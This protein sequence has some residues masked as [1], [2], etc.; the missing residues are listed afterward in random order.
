MSGLHTATPPA[1]SNNAHSPSNANKTAGTEANKRENSVIS[2][3]AAT[4]A[5]RE[6]VENVEKADAIPLESSDS[7]ASSD[8]IDWISKFD[9][10]EFCTATVDII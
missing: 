8:G 1:H 2:H 9:F 4:A 10:L 5:A 6:A 3:S 7:L